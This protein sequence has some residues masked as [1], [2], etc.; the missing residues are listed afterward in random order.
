MEVTRPRWS[1]NWCGDKQSQD[2]ATPDLKVDPVDGAHGLSSPGEGDLQIT[3]V[4]GD[5]VVSAHAGSFKVAGAAK[6]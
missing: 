6:V 3:N 4:D 1:A 5:V 2:F